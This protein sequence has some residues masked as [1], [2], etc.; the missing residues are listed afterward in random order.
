MRW[1][2]LFLAATVAMAMVLACGGTGSPQGD[3]AQ[4]REPESPTPRPTQSPTPSPTPSPAPSP[5]PSPTP[6]PIPAPEEQPAGTYDNPLPAGTTF[7]LSEGMDDAAQ[8]EEL[9]EVT[10]DTTDQD[11][12]DRV[13]AEFEG[14]E[15]AEG[16]TPAMVPVTLTYVGPQTGT[17]GIDLDF[18]IVGSDGNTY[19]SAPDDFCGLIPEDLADHG[20]MFPGATV[21]GNVCYAVPDGVIEGGAWIVALSFAWD[22][23]RVF[24]SVD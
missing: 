8:P 23:Q 24:V 15:I 4:T 2:K 13:M 22:D 9:W 11:A 16:R 14:N 12:T 10:L 19:S 1:L 6:S 5:T 17:P 21:S 7:V 20:E 18:R 3:G